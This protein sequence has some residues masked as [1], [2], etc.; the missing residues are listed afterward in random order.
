MIGKNA[1]FNQAA[2]E[3]PQVA[4]LTAEWLRITPQFLRP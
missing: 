4:I 1:E 3:F 2:L